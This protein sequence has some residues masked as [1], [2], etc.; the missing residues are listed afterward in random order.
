MKGQIVANMNRLTVQERA[1]TL[2]ARE[3]L[4]TI[5]VE[6]H[7]N[8]GNRL[9]NQEWR[10]KKVCTDLVDDANRYGKERKGVHKVGRSIER[11]GNPQPLLIFH[12]VEYLGITNHSTIQPHYPFPT[13]QT[14][15]HKEH[16]S[17][18]SPS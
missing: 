14:P 1:V 17:G 16:E 10:T 15:D 4:V 6:N 11:I 9:G 7:A 2:D 13:P 18:T 3:H 8:S 12:T 5:G